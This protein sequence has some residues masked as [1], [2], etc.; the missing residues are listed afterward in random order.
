MTTAGGLSRR[1]AAAARAVGALAAVTAGLAAGYAVHDPG[2]LAAGL[3]VAIAAMNGR[4]KAY[5]P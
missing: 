5:S 2:L 1:R 4:A 3:A